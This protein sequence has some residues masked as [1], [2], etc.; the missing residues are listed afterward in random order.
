MKAVGASAEPQIP[1]SVQVRTTAPNE[2]VEERTLSE[3]RL[4]KVDL[5]EADLTAL[6]ATDAEFDA[7]NLA[8]A[9]MP[10]VA[11]YR[12]VLLQSKLSGIQVTK[13]TFT[14]VRFRDCRLDFAAFNQAKFKN[15]TFEGCQ[16]READ[17]ASVTL[18]HVAFVDC[19]LTRATFAGVQLKQTEMRRCALGELRGL[20]ALRGVAMEPADIPAN[21]ELFATELGIRF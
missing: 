10:N 8:N 3:V 17:F 9:T 5:T 6:H 16:L 7:C 15:V 2:L 12:V 1:E 13:A 20:S 19:D 11:F 21:A 18:D 4:A 14:D